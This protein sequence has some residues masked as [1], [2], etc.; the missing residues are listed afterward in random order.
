MSTIH[1]H[2][3][4]HSY[5][6]SFTYI[7]FTFAEY[8]LF[9]R[10]LLQKSP[11]KETILPFA[12]IHSI[13]VENDIWSIC[14]IWTICH[15][16]LTHMVHHSHTYTTYVEHMSLM[17]HMC[18]RRHIC[19]G[20]HMPLHMTPFTARP[21]ESCKN[22]EGLAPPRCPFETG[23]TVEQIISTRPAWSDGNEKPNQIA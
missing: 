5:G 8:G 20:P 1:I 2:T 7:H 9:Y 21:Y 14:G 15:S 23:T 4:R 10:A 11:I 16:P 13:N 18:D 6:P 19:Q 17:H 3:L 22:I 12:Y